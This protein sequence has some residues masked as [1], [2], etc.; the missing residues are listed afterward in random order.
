ML[1]E[2][3][4]SA[5]TL[6]ANPLITV[7]ALS[8]IALGIGSNAAI[9]AVVNAVLLRPLPFPAS[10][11]LVAVHSRYLPSTGYDFPFFA[12]SG[13]EFL[14]LQNRVQA[15]SAIAAFGLAFQTITLPSGE[16]ER[17]LTMPV[18][19]R[20]F[21]VLGVRPQQGRAITEEDTERRSGCVAVLRHDADK[22]ASGSAAAA[23]GTTIRLDDVPCTVVGIM[24]EGFGFRDNRV[25]VWTALAVD[26][27]ETPQN[28]ASHGL[29]AIA[30][31]REDV[32]QARARVTSAAM[33]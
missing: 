10:D 25:K 17:V 8:T 21:D 19:S 11:R 5:R 26:T 16:V 24:P 33:V 20:F 23:V 29:L 31:L 22:G 30:R 27:S 2:L 13:P 1:Q 15:F 9:F 32:T 18:S 12:L 28:R 14:D 3:R 7:I 6:R 4:V